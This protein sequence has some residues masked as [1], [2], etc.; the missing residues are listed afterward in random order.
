MEE[1]VLGNEAQVENTRQVN[2]S[3]KHSR[4]EKKTTNFDSEKSPETSTSFKRS[5]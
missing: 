5:F 3:G 4:K 1:V 2:I